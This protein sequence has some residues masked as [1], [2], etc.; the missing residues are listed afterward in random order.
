[1]WADSPALESSLPCV[2]QTKQLLLRLVPFVRPY[3]LLI[4]LNLALMLFT[5]SMTLAPPY[6][7][8]VLLDDVLPHRDLRRLFLVIAALLAISVTNSIVTAVRRYLATWLEQRV[9]LRLRMDLY[10]HLHRLSLGFYDRQ[11]SGHV[12]QRIMTDTT[13]LQTFMATG[14]E[15]LTE[16]VMTILVIAVIMLR[17][18]PGLALITLGPVPLIVWGNHFGSR[19]KLHRLYR[20]AWRQSAKLNSILTDTL[21]GM[22]VVKAFG[23][24]GGG[25]V[26][27]FVVTN[28]ELQA[29]NLRAARLGR[30]FYPL[31]GFLS[32]LGTMSIW[33]YGGLPGD[34]DGRAHRGRA[35]RLHSVPRALLPADAPAPAT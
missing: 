11:G 3:W 34:P 2:P 16:H 15:E 27:R 10:E 19:I 18:D 17:M 5:T 29:T 9:V 30:T 22:R 7:T 20:R 32:T 28:R 31:M 25:E 33:A 6:L 24:E 26:N 21:P 8:K 1:M 13:P 35:H 4:V 14:L 12:I 23:Q